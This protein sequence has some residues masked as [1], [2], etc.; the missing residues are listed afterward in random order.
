[1][2]LKDEQKALD[3]LWDLARQGNALAI[4]NLINFIIH[5]GRA[6]L[7]CFVRRS[8]GGRQTG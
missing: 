1:M 5:Q 3:G 4:E 6:F 8:S 7:I 2:E